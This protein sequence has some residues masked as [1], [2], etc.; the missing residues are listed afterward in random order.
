[1]TDQNKIPVGYMSPPEHSRFK[2]GQSGNPKGR[3]RKQEDIFTLLQRVLKRKIKV[4]GAERQMPICEALIRKL[5]EQALLGD[6]R[7]L[8]LQ[9]HILDEAAV[10]RPEG[11][12]PEEKKR[13]VLEGLSRMGVKIK[14]NGDGNG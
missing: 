7:A 1:M 6:P 3:P 2:K 5:K 11:P 4:K 9:R 14:R 10:N 8:S 13:Q 12:D